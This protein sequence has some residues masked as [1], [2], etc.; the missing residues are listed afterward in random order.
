MHGFHKK[1]LIA[2]L[3]AVALLVLAYFLL[4]RTTGQVKLGPTQRLNE[5][6]VQLEKL[7]DQPSTKPLVTH[8][9]QL[10]ADDNW[11]GLGAELAVLRHGQDTN[12][13]ARQ[14]LLKETEDTNGNKQYPHAT[15]VGTWLGA[16]RA[17]LAGSNTANHPQNFNQFLIG[18]N[19]ATKTAEAG[20][21]Y[22]SDFA[23]VLGD[24]NSRNLELASA[25]ELIGYIEIK[26]SDITAAI[27][28]A[29]GVG[30]N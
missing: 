22:Q 28:K 21:N 30:P 20:I 3:A 24:V 9:K 27:E 2:G 6:V 26:E 17:A 4:F 5:A 16:S 23:D 12:I 8:I 25:I 15:R 19:T 13:P 11:L 18:L 7:I 14:Y 1:Y 10:I 29:M